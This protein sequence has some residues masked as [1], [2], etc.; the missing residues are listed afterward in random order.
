L[1]SERTSSTKV[2]PYYARGVTTPTYQHWV[3]GAVD[4]AIRRTDGA[5]T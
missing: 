1:T 3:R 2:V 4:A 5:A